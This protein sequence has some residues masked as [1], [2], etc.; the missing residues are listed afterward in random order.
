MKRALLRQ[1]HQRVVDVQSVAHQGLFFEELE[2]KGESGEESPA[3]QDA[4]LE[5]FFYL[6]R[7]DGV[8][9]RHLQNIAMSVVGLTLLRE[10]VAARIFKRHRQLNSIQAD[11]GQSHVC[12][13]VSQEDGETLLLWISPWK[14]DTFTWSFFNSFS[15]FPLL[16]L[17][18]CMWKKSW[19]YAP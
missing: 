11:S 4:S 12:R 1:N 15:N 10:G 2:D 13:D 9:Q 3:G 16:T 6:L 5:S 7:H 14:F 19:L 17:I 8:V 18:N